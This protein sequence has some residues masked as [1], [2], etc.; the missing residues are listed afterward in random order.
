MI[1]GKW[2]IGKP[3]LIQ[4]IKDDPHKLLED[5]PVIQVENLRFAD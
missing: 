3:L 2:V 5:Q 1:E 4:E